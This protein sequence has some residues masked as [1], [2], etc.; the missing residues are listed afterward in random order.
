MVRTLLFL[1]RHPPLAV[2]R[3]LA[4]VTSTPRLTTRAR[5]GM[6]CLVLWC[7]PIC[8]RMDHQGK[9]AGGVRKAARLQGSPWRVSICIGALAASASFFFLFFLSFF[10]CPLN[11]SPPF[12]LRREGTKNRVQTSGA[13]SG[14]GRECIGTR[15]RHGHRSSVVVRKTKGRASRVQNLPSI[16]SRELRASVGGPPSSFPGAM[17]QRNKGGKARC[18]K[19]YL[20]ALL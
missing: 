3:G 9:H 4:T 17:G 15:L 10:F 14:H 2:G 8:A 7:V 11:L 19:P 16:F 1:P 20:M 13:S 5:T 18:G 12:F 6:V